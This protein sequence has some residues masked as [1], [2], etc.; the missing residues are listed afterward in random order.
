MVG[1]VIDK[2]SKPIFLG[3]KIPEIFICHSSLDEKLLEEIKITIE[4]ENVTPFLA[5]E[6]IHGMNPMEKIMLSVFRCDALFAI[7]TKNAI[8]NQSTRDWIFFEIGLA[9]GMWM[10]ED[11]STKNKKSRKV[12]KQYR[13]YGWKDPKIILP[14]GN[15]LKF[16]TDYKPLIKRSRK[17]R[18]KM[19]EEMKEIAQEI[20]Y[21]STLP[22]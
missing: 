7:L 9:K 3:R 17:S 19:L 22:S 18:D 16:I 14:E 4:R 1:V 8:L 20:Y 6:K 13:I 21:A 5:S 10:K 12:W 11:M 2:Y 15:P